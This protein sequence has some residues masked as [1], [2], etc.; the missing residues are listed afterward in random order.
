MSLSG[1]VS[2]HLS[3]RWTFWVVRFILIRTSPRTCPRQLD[4]KY[5]LNESHLKE[6]QE[7]VFEWLAGEDAYTLHKP[8]RINWKRNRVVIR[9]IEI[10]FTSRPSLHDHLLKGK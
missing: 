8:V 4:I 7:C 1:G 2:K 6:A 5:L 10:H 9:G 3:L